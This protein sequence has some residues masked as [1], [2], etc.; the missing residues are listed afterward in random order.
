MVVHS[1]R[2]L[3]TGGSGHFGPAI[4]RAFLREGFNV[5]ILLHRSRIRSLER[6]TEVVWGDIT[7]PDSVRRALDGVDAVVHM[8]G[9]VEPSTESD[10]ELA[11]R[12]NV[13]GTQTIVGVI[14]E[15]GGTIP[16][17]FISS[18]AVFGPTPDATECLHPD[19]NPCD[20]VSVY[21]RTKLEA[22]NLIRESGIDHVILRLTA[23]P[24]SKISRN[25]V[26]TQMY[27]VPLKNRTEFCHP[28]D[29]ALAI[30]NS[31][32]RFDA[33][34]DRTLVIAGGP[35]QQMYYEDLVRASLGTF[36][37][38]LPPRH[39]FA[40]GSFPLHWYDTS[41]SQACLGYQ[42]KTLDDY[43]RDLAGQFP[44]PLLVV[45]RRFI[46]PVFGRLIVRLM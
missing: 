29:A 18:V 25:D 36:G 19:R 13:G 34:K 10:P 33:A 46:G 7:E 24:Y 42:R 27:I 15:R 5:R 9:I 40:E 8:A 44:A 6:E 22:E 43:A 3:I 21:A 41:E 12:V 38:P 31:V 28:D 14:K 16:F 45:M 26:K 4:C 35:S 37:L 20:P 30:V 32:R 2:V 1:Q 11:Q 39:K 23:T 17:T